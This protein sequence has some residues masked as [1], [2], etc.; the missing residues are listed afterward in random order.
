MTKAF[1]Q[2][3]FDRIA[4]ELPEVKKVGIYNQDFEKMETGEKHLFNFPAIFLSFPEV[5]SYSNYSSGVQNTNEFT[6]RLLI[7]DKYFTDEDVLNIFDLKQKV[8]SK[9]HKFSPVTAAS[10]MERIAETTDENRRGFYIFEQDYT[11]RLQ[12]ST[13][14]ILNDRVEVNP[15]SLGLNSDLKIDANTVEGV[16]TDKKE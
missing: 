10:S 15:W 2:S 6:I 7:A 1:I 11:V 8:Y 5:V 13:K 16:R 12:D 9:F 3:I 14:Y 4:V